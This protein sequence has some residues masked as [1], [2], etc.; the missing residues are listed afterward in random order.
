VRIIEG[1]GDQAV[2]FGIKA[3]LR[4][5]EVEGDNIRRSSPSLALDTAT[6]LTEKQAQ[7][8]HPLSEL[9]AHEQSDFV[10]SD[11]LDDIAT[12]IL[13]TCA[14][15][16]NL[17][18]G[19]AKQDLEVLA[20]RLHA[21]VKVL[22]LPHDP[23]HVHHGSLSKDVRAETEALLKSGHPAT[24][25][26]SSTLEMGI[27]I[28]SVR[29]VAQLDP[30]W[31][32]ASMRQRLGR[33]GRRDGEPACMCLY[34]R[35]ESPHSGS[36]V[37]DLLF[38]NLI[39]AVSLTRLMLSKWLEPHDG[40][41]LHLST[42]VHQILSCLRESGGMSAASLYAN[43]IRIGAFGGVSEMMFRRVLKSLGNQE[44]IE[45][46][47]TGELILAPKGERITSDRDFYAAFASSEEFAIR[48]D[49]RE[50][51]KL[52]SSLVPPQG[53]NLI[54]GG[55]RWCVIDINSTAKTVFVAPAKGGK[56][57][58]FRGAGGEI[59][60]RVV[61]EM[62]CVLADSDEP[63]YLDPSGQ[64]LL[65]AARQIARRTGVLSPGYIVRTNSVQWF[66]WLGTRGM[67]TL[68]LHARCAGISAETD[69]LSITY[70]ETDVDRWRGHLKS[71]QDGN[72]N[73]LALAQT[74]AVKTFEKF[75]EAL[76]ETLLD[77]ANAHDRLDLPSAS[78]RARSMLE[79]CKAD[80]Q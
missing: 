41:R 76:D 12:H 43:L 20:D 17:V 66:P 33:S 28:G 54:L 25:L 30:P 46:V 24:V 9:Q 3:Y 63:L 60:N 45:Q 37:T 49:G 31:S 29:R 36:S 23:F 14:Q 35:D 10:D 38:P 13:N 67:L 2:K 8:A 19:N 26:C 70:M 47:P 6:S 74:M 80:N 39:R 21:L 69:L 57:P 68:K 58:V 55:R 71:I 73:A 11:E 5:E 7:L 72:Y 16:T 1:K 51:G 77:E 15:H 44:I 75:D 78:A 22:K 40:D 32:V 42:L 52:Q 79:C 48:H 34:S 65:K 27:D 64:L 50:L 53:E 61:E 59:H 4:G 18:F 56:A 62:R